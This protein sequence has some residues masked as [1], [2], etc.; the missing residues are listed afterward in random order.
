MSKIKGIASNCRGTALAV[1]KQEGTITFIFILE[2]DM[3]TRQLGRELYRFDATK[4]T[5]FTWSLTHPFQY[6]L[7]DQLVDLTEKLVDGKLTLINPYLNK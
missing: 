7:D 1:S 5:H 3:N 6:Y 2:Y 4:I